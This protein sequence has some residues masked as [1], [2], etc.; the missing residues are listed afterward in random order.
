MRE[1]S[2]TLDI[3]PADLPAAMDPEESALISLEDGY[4]VIIVDIPIPVIGQNGGICRDDIKGT[5]ELFSTLLDNRL[6]NAMKYLTSVTPIMAVPTVVS[7]LYG[8]NVNLAGMPFAV[9]VRGFLIVCCMILAVCAVA[10][11]ILHQKHM[12]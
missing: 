7:G 11:C 8:M 9:S 12:L 1:V 3:E 10:A 5:R 2:L 6:N 4:A